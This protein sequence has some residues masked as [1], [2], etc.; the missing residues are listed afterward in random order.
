MVSYL[1]KEEEQDDDEDTD[2][3]MD[4]GSRFLQ[5]LSVPC[6]FCPGIV[7]KESADGFPWHQLNGKKAG[8]S[9]ELRGG[10][11]ISM[12]IILHRELS[13]QQGHLPHQ[14]SCKGE[15]EGEGEVHSAQT[16]THRVSGLYLQ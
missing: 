2:F 5:D 4:P 16:G 7:I 9:H 6:V 12:I 11:S 1:H 10:K 15:M 14:N 8:L 13:C 3:R